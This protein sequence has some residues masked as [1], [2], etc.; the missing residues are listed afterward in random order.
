MRKPLTIVI[1]DTT[2]GEKHYNKHKFSL[3]VNDGTDMWF[4]ECPERGIEEVLRM[5]ARA[6]DAARSWGKPEKHAPN[7]NPCPQCERF[8]LSPCPMSDVKRP[9]TISDVLASEIFPNGAGANMAYV[10]EENRRLRE[11]NAA[12]TE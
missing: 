8:H 3:I 10:A 5:A 4:W 7:E 1:S 6:V 2:L 11:A 9:E 12:L